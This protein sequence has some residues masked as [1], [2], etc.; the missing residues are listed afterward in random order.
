VQP[1]YFS[2]V[3]LARP[4]DTTQLHLHAILLF[5]RD[6]QAEIVAAVCKGENHEKVVSKNGYDWVT[7]R[8]NVFNRNKT[9]FG[10]EAPRRC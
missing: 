2:A 8:W 5:S 6:I 10:V 1:W 3:L 7:D 9:G 4:M